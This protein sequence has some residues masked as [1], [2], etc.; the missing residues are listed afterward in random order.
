MITIDLETRSDRDLKKCG[1]YAYTESLQFEILLFSYSIDGSEV[2]VI[3][4]ANG[5]KIPDEIISALTDES[6]IK[7]A[8]NVNFERICLSKYL[9]KKY[10]SPIGWHCSMIHARTLRLPSSLVEVG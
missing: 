3:D 1:V 9:G 8:F 5:E 4:L 7:K 6:I 2:Q 10:L